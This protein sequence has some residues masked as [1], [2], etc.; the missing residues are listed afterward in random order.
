MTQLAY[1]QKDA[2]R[3]LGV[4]VSHFQRHVRPEL[5]IPVVVGGRLLFKHR[6]LERWLEGRQCQAR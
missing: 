5:P 4:S 6:D 3:M 2:A 1:S